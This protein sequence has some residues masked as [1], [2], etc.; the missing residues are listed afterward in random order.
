MKNKPVS[1]V[2]SA[3]LGHWPVILPA[4]G[5]TVPGGGKHGAC[6]A[7]GG[8]DRFRFDDKDGRGTWFCNQC[9]SGDGL[10][11]VRNA[12]EL[13]VMAAAE[14]VASTV[15]SDRAAAVSNN[16]PARKE[17]PK[18]PENETWEAAQTAPDHH[19]YLT[20][21]GLGDLR[22]AVVTT[23]FRRGCL[24]L[25]FINIKGEQCGAQWVDAYGKKGNWK[26]SHKKGAFILIRPERLP[27]TTS[28]III[29]EG[30]ATA[31]S[32]AMC[33][34]GVAVA[35]I[36]EGNLKPVAQALREKYPQAKIIIAADNDW[37]SPEEKDQNGKPKQNGGL[38]YGEQAAKAVAGWLSLPP[39]EVKADWDDYRQKH[40][41]DDT[42][43]TFCASLKPYGENRDN[44]APVPGAERRPE[45]HQMA[46]N[47]IAEIVAK[48]YGMVRTDPETGAIF[49]YDG[50]VWEVIPDYRLMRDT[51]ALFSEN[52]TPFG[53]GKI[54]N[55]I[56][57]MRLILDEIG[58]QPSSVIGFANCIYD[59]SK[60]EFRPHS[61][62]NWLRTH[63]GIV[64]S[65]AAPHENVE[66][67][68]PAFWRW[69]S[70]AASGSPARMARIKAALFMVLANRYDWQMFIE[71]TGRGGSGKSVFAGIATMLA[72]EHNTEPADMEMLDSRRDR[73]PLF[74]KSL[75]VLPDQTQ[76]VGSGSGLKAITGGD[77]VS[78][79][80]KHMKP[81][82]AII[83][84]V[85]LVT[86]N[87]PMK[88]TENNGGISRR[89][90]I[91]AFNRPVEDEQKD[92]DL[93]DKIA[94]ELPVII[95]HLL[96]EF[97][98]Q[99]KARALLLEQRNSSDAMTVKA[100]SSPLY[101]FCVH[102]QQID[103]AR[104]GMGMGH[105]G[106]SPESPRGYIYHAY[107]A[108]MDACHNR[109][110]ALTLNKFV[111]GFRNVTKEMGLQ[112]EEHRL[113]KGKRYNLTLKEDADEWLPQLPAKE[114]IN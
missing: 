78:I 104:S 84:A 72:G 34:D 23:P 25:P 45:L 103:D 113:K 66:Q 7:C 67:H 35:A 43:R 59:R 38:L 20:R 28:N 100:V 42:K 80:P 18:I 90:V 70:H 13:D 55:T 10:D 12:L 17:A 96:A 53:Q 111:E 94:A 27:E 93:L 3:A 16:T 49:R 5:I 14:K 50:A 109:R 65:E 15:G 37:Y 105:A 48:R 41:I 22:L 64:F 71:A 75:I 40:G 101:G 57:T 89:R 61:P 19:P 83:K 69:L 33:H 11:L 21:K 8:K 60:Q 30:A 62:E 68:A 63:N 1:N 82:S 56:E 51:T 47:Q 4:L 98:D 107:L 102:L 88:F 81:F 46:P 29:A 106:I 44:P 91:F 52:K 112:V 79:D 26:G 108:Y 9:G 99:E 54:K 87:E 114:K 86:C 39:G 92:P 24:Y 110:H 32:A 58:E 95:R 2:I 85:V 31:I 73:A 76:Y 6:P 36:D 77:R 74:G 97:A